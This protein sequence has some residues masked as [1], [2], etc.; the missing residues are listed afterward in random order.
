MK[1]DVE[2]DLFANFALLL[3]QLNINNAK[4]Q[5]EHIISITTTIQSN[6]RTESVSCVHVSR[7][8]PRIVKTFQRT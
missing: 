6:T 7:I 1:S 8:E 4:K 2:L 5:N 3:R